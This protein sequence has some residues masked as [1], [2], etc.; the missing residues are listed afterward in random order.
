[1]SDRKKLSPPASAAPDSS[2]AS[3]EFLLY[4]TEDGRT[5]IFA[6]D[7]VATFLPLTH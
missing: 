7:A 6:E 2:S 4:Q 5:R 1:M 3:G